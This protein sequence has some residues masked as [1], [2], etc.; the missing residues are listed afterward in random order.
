MLTGTVGDAAGGVNRIVTG[1]DPAG[2]GPAACGAGGAVPPA[3][4]PLFLPPLGSGV[5]NAAS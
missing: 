4:K 3:S 1:V 2:A 5:S